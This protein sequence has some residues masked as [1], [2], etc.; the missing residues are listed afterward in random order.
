MKTGKIEQADGISRRSG[1]YHQYIKKKK[2]QIERRRAKSDP[3]CQPLYGRYK[4][5]ET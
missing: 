4:G 3:E 5:W 2:R 1:G